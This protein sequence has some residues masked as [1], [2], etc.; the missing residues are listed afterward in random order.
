MSR[1]LRV[2]NFYHMLSWAVEQSSKYFCILFLDH[3]KE[4]L[5]IK[6]V[7]VQHI[8][9]FVFMSPEIN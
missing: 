9:V 8:F 3:S 7:V 5:S 6:L 1:V 4:N 2:I